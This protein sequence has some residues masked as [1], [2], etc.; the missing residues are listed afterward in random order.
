MREQ[1][2]KAIIIIM[3]FS[4]ITCCFVCTF[5]GCPIAHPGSVLIPHP[6]STIS[7]PAPNSKIHLK[8]A[9]TSV[10]SCSF[11]DLLQLL[12]R[13]EPAVSISLI[14]A[15]VFPLCDMPFP[16]PRI[17]FPSSRHRFAPAYSRLRYLAIA[18]FFPPVN[19]PS[20]LW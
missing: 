1:T 8:S 16:S 3:L 9:P 7:L 18:A 2:I 6:S 11:P 10:F 14:Q 12:S 15:W 17:A 4:A 5:P 19:R 20:R 13:S